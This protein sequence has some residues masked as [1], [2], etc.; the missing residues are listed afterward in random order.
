M[1]SEELCRADTPDH[2]RGGLLFATIFALL[3][4]PIHAQAWIGDTPNPRSDKCQVAPGP[5]YCA[6]WAFGNAKE[7][8]YGCMS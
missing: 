7:T 8:Y 1:I 3:L 6:C 4:L 2:M 5:A